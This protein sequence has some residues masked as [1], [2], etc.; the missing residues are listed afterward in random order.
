MLRRRT[1]RD[2][3]YL[4][5]T[6][7]TL[8]GGYT[9]LRAFQPLPPGMAGLGTWDRGNAPDDRSQTLYSW[10]AT[11]PPAAGGALLLAPRAHCPRV[12]G[13]ICVLLHGG[14]RFAGIAG[15]AAAMTAVIL[16]SGLVG[17]YL[18]TALDRNTEDWQM[19]HHALQT[20]IHHL[21]KSLGPQLAS[22]TGIL[23]ELDEIATP[24]TGWRL[25]VTRIWAPWR[26]KRL[27]QARLSRQA[28]CPRN[29][30]GN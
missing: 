8:I 5:L 24:P 17:R 28:D 4:L 11:H 2:V 9:A 7:L 25:Y 18:Y 22:L 1:N 12:L 3:R 21:S 13:G 23:S 15:V 29:F 16:T 6:A 27:I 10:Q 19:N 30:T 20:R 14:G 26:A